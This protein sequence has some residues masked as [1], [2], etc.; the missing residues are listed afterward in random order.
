MN[1]KTSCLL[2]LVILPMLSL[3]TINLA[4]SAEDFYSIKINKIYYPIETIENSTAGT[5]FSLK[6]NY[7]ISH[8]YETSFTYQSPNSACLIPRVI[9]ELEGNQSCYFGYW[10]AQ[11]MTWCLFNLTVPNYEIILWLTIAETELTDLVQG[12]YTIW[13]QFNL[14][15]SEYLIY[16]RAFITVTDSQVIITYEPD[17]EE[18]TYTLPNDTKMVTPVIIMTLLIVSAIYWKRKKD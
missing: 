6:I 7:S 12:K 2:F 16:Y 5:K 18:D 9:A 17:M 3:Q 14:P 1:K 4:V 15:A 8:P 11:V 10:Y 13:L